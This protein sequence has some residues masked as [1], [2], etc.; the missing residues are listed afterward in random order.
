MLSS[1]LKVKVKKYSFLVS[2]YHSLLDGDEEELI[3]LL[4]HTVSRPGGGRVDERN[5]N[6]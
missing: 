1:L 6:L 2:G 4:V 3:I 5:V